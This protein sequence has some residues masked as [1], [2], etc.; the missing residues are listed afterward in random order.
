MTAY[1]GEIRHLDM[2]AGWT[3]HPHRYWLRRC[4]MCKRRRPLTLLYE[5]YPPLG[6]NYGWW[7]G[8]ASCVESS[9]QFKQD[10]GE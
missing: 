3:E 2:L 4:D 1:I 10:A 5:C 8:C 6:S 9:D 7:F